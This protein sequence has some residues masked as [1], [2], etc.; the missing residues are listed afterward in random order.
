[1]TSS[2]PFT[3][4]FPHA[5]GIAYRPT[6]ATCGFVCSSLGR[7]ERDDS[8]QSWLSHLRHTGRAI[9]RVTVVCRLKNVSD[10]TRSACPSNPHGHVNVSR[11]R[12]VSSVEPQFG[13]SWL[14]HAS[15]RTSTLIPYSSA[16]HVNR[17]TNARNAQKL[18]VFA[19]VSTDQCVSS[20]SGSTAKSR[21]RS[22]KLASSWR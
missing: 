1:M 7:G 12:V 19:F 16:V 14:V 13:H 20:T 6:E 5:G 15:D 2:S 10:A 11:W 18:C 17:F 22:R 4:R 9:D 8:N 3:A 21:L